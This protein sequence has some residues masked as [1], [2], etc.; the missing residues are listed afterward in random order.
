MS[1]R[2]LYSARRKN[3]ARAGASH[4]RQINDQLE[5]HLVSSMRTKG[6]GPQ[7]L[8]FY[9]AV[10]LHY[11]LYYLLSV[12]LSMYSHTARS[13]ASICIDFVADAAEQCAL[14]TCAD[15]AHSST[16]WRS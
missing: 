8:Y 5:L 11:C 10:V 7:E 4:P 15:E 12:L 3:N 6:A 14:P 9:T 2:C 16:T 1:A 13:R